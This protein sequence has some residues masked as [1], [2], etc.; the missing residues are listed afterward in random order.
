[1]L[2]KIKKWLFNNQSTDQTIAKNTFWL[3]FGQ[4]AGRLLRAVIV[5]YAA[6]IL[7]AAGWGAFSYAM[8]AAAFLTIFS[9]IG[10]NA[11]ITRET[12]RNP[13][14][15]NQYLATAFFIKIGLLILLIIGVA[16]FFPYLT[17]LPEAAAIMPI[18]IFI[19]AFD[20]LRELGSAVSRALE[21][22]E[23]ESL[24]QIFTNFIIVILGFLFLAL[25]PD[26][27]TLALAYAF[28]SGLGL[29]AIFYILKI[30]IRNFWA[31][32][33]SGLIKPILA[34]A[35]PFGLIGLMGAVMLN[36]DIIMLGWLRSAAEVGYYSAAQKPIQLLYVLP[37]LLASSI[38][39]IMARFAKTNPTLIKNILEKYAALAILTAAPIA[40][41]GLVSAQPIIALLFGSEYLPA[42]AAFKILLLTVLIVF[43]STILTNAI[44]AYDRQKS[45]VI[46]AASAFIGNIVFNFLLIPPLGIKGA[47]ISTILTQLIT[48]GLIWRKIQKISG[49][50]IWSRVFFYGSRIFSTTRNLTALFRRGRY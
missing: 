22:M 2:A 25:K 8:G 39:P 34:G 5:I 31:D 28:G 36:T 45:F 7:G 15:K 46:F 13:Q 33:K 6:R 26:A 16:A 14:L 43:P 12:S 37:T 42:V 47:A 50:A 4:T 23:I 10:I 41:L 44:F 29:A 48:N 3:F 24:T 21:K 49:A 11:L 19:F 20:T 9:D 18:V 35:W 1:M 17:N 27:K 32:F 40:I 38:F 30:P